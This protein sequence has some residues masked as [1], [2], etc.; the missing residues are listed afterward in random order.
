MTFLALMMEKEDHQPRNLGRIQK[1]EKTRKQILTQSQEKEIQPRENFGFYLGKIRVGLTD[2]K[3]I[4]SRLVVGWWGFA[5]TVIKS[6]YQEG[7]QSM[8]LGNFG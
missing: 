1:L 8:E 5:K 6:L 7:S 2:D 4:C 3:F